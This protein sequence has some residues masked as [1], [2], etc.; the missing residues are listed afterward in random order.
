MKLQNKVAIIT[1]STRGIGNAAAK[2]FAA[3]GAKVVIVGTKEEAGKKCVEE[4]EAAGGTAFFR[5]TNLSSE[6]DMHGLV[7]DTLQTYGKID[8]LVNNA[9][10]DDPL[11][12]EGVQD[13][14]ME[15]WN[16]VMNINVTAPFFL[17]KLV[18]AEMEKTG[19]GVILNTGSVASTGA[20]R[21]PFVYTV[22]KHALLGLTRELSVY[23]GPKGIR[24]NAILPGGVATDMIAGDLDPSNPAVAKIM[25]CPAGRVATVDEVAKVML[26]L[27][28]DDASYIHGTGVT[29]DGGFT[30]L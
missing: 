1:G 9:G 15:T 20:A 24:V 2:C 27:V 3:E 13:I 11:V 16:R 6:E 28:S 22:S 7:Q 4:I 18:I 5:K 10:T 21:G 19:G 26:F 8:I 25:A 30:L 29:V 23:H 14:S 12:I 17:S